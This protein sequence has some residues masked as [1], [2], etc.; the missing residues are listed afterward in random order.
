MQEFCNRNTQQERRNNAGVTDGDR[1]RRLAAQDA[2][3]QP[4]S[5]HK[6]EQNDAQLTQRCQRQ[7]FRGREQRLHGPRSHGP[8]HGR[9]QCQSGNQ[10]A[11]DRGLA[12]QSHNA[13]YEARRQQYDN[14]LCE[15]ET[16]VEHARPAAKKPRRQPW[17]GCASQLKS[18]SSK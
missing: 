11:Y 8:Q 9:P 17:M 15:E 18:R 10:L 7:H 1:S 13:P 12:H 14:Q 16:Q 5:D 6:H 4:Q 2:D 3:V